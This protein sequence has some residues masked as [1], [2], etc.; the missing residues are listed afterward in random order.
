MVSPWMKRGALLLAFAA[1]GLPAQLDAQRV[2]PTRIIDIHV[3]AEAENRAFDGSVVEGQRFRIS[4]RGSGSYEI[5]PVLV[6]AQAGRFRVTVFAGPEG[7]EGAELRQAGTV[8]ARRGVPVALPGMRSVSLVI[9]GVRRAENAGQGSVQLI[10]NQLPTA[11]LP[12]FQTECCVEC[13]NITACGCRVVH[14]C[15]FCCVSPCCRPGDPITQTA[16]AR[17]FPAG[18]GLA[19]DVGGCGNPIKDE[20]RIFTPRAGAARIAFT[21]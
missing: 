3:N 21:R 8:D 18:R 16:A 5:M 4:I 11:V 13:G 1:A 10:S 14:S 17:V 9:D 7:A 6:D 2:D 20:E 12:T 19:Q 15:D